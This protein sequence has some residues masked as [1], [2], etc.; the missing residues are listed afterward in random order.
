MIQPLTKEYISDISIAHVVAWQKAF[1]GILSEEQLDNLQVQDFIKGWQHN[2]CKEGR[3]NLIRFL[4][5]T[6]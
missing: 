3:T 1:R 6:L 2:I 4:W 5:K